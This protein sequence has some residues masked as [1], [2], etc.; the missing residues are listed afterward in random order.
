MPID[1]SSLLGP[2]VQPA[3]IDTYSYTHRNRKVKVRFSPAFEN[4]EI[5][6]AFPHLVRVIMEAPPKDMGADFLPL[7]AWQEQ[8]TNAEASL[9]KTLDKDSNTAKWAGNFMYEGRLDSA[10]LVRDLPSFQEAYNKWYP[11]QS[12]YRTHIAYSEDKSS[13]F[14]A[15]FP[16]PHLRR[17]ISDRLLIDSIR[18]QG[19]NVDALH[20][21]ELKFLGKKDDLKRLHELLKVENMFLITPFQDMADTGYEQTMVLATARKLELE[22]MFKATGLAESKALECDC[23]LESWNTQAVKDQVLTGS[24]KEGYGEYIWEKGLIYKGPWKNSKRNGWGRMFF[25]DGSYFEG[26]FVDNKRTGKGLMAWSW[27]EVFYGD[28]LNGSLHGKGEYIWPHG[29][30]YDGDWK[31]GSRTGTGVYQWKNGDIYRG[32]FLK[33]LRH[34]KGRIDYSDGGWFEGSFVEGKMT[35]FGREFVADKNEIH[36]GTL[37]DGTWQSDKKI[38]SLDEPKEEPKEEPTIAP[39]EGGSPGHEDDAL[40]G[41]QAAPPDLPVDA[42]PGEEP[43]QN[44][45]GETPLNIAIKWVEIGDDNTTPLAEL[46]AMHRSAAE[47][48]GLDLYVLIYEDWAPGAAALKGFMA[49]PP[50]SLQLMGKY[51]L[52]IG[53]KWMADINAMGQTSNAI[54]ELFEVGPNGVLTGKVIRGSAW[55]PDT[56]ENIAGALEKFFQ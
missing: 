6:D 18:K 52:Q 15:L 27:D 51:I 33:S 54:P 11:K 8:L 23:R 9:V 5:Q 21:M 38:T 42:L 46:L 44:S 47:A 56:V 1:P 55:G 36:E 39:Q 14:D 53:A 35:G 41:G 37:E 2:K 25:E 17:Q 4:V 48:D 16:A 31:D 10:F 13:V 3:R 12:A 43:A 7:P 49:T 32:D 20:W 50:V 19:T 26:D 30:K 45:A 28:F 34:G 24:I 22:P 40:P 29:A